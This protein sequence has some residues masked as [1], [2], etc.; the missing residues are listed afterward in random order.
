M[1]PNNFPKAF[2]E[3][4]LADEDVRLECVAYGY[5]VPSYNWTRLN[6]GGSQGRLPEGSYTTSHNRVLIIPKV[7]VEDMGEY[8][9]AASS[10]RDVISKIVTLSIQALP[11][12]KSPLTDKMMDRGETL[13]WACSAFG[14]PD[15]SYKWYK[16]GRELEPRDLHFEDGNRYKIRDNV[17]VIEGLTPGRDEGLYQCRAWN[18]LGSRFTSGQLTIQSLKPNFK[19]H[20]LDAEM[21]A[22]VGS[23]FTIR[24]Q[25]EAIPFPAFQWK[26]NG[27]FFGGG[28]RIQVLNNGYLHI[29]SV[30]VSDAGTY[31]CV[32][33]N[34]HGMDQTEGFLT[35][36]AQPRIVE[37]PRPKVVARVNDTIQ[38]ECLAYADNSLDVAYIWL[39]NGLR[40]N[41]TRMPQFSSGFDL[42]Y[43]KIS[44]LTFAEAGE[45]QCIVKTSVGMTAVKTELII[46]GPPNSP[47][48]VLAEELTATSAK[49]MWSDGSDNG[50]RTL[51]YTIEGRTNHNPEWAL[52]AQ[53]VTSFTADPQTGRRS[54]YVHN[55]LSPWSTYEF[56]V[57]AIN[58][59]GQGVP[60]DAS[61]QYNTE[62]APPLKA[63]F[64]VGGGG[65]K[66]GTLTITWSPL[67]P[68]DWNAP[69]IWYKIYYKAENEIDYRS[70]D[71]KAL[72]NIGLYTVSV[73]EENYFKRYRVAVKAINSYGEGPSSLEHEVYS[74]ESMPQ[75]QPSL[76]KAYPFN[77]T[78]LNVSW[79]PLD[80]TREKIRGRLIG[81][82]I[83]YWRNGHD[84][85]SDSQTLLSRGVDP[86]G[87]IVALQ[88]DNEY[89]VAV[90]AY[91][92][93]GSGPES[94][95][96]LARTYKASPQRPPTSVKVT[97]RDSTSV[98]VTW[99][100]VSTVGSN[101][102]PILGY[103]VRY[104]ESDQPIAKAREV[105]KYLDGGD[106]EAVISGL[107]PGKV[108][109]L[110]VLAYSWGGDGKMSS[111]AWEFRVGEGSP[112]KYSSFGSTI[113][114]T[115]MAALIMVCLIVNRNLT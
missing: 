104:W 41:F 46:H 28:G 72:G 30:Q 86:W 5:P 100:G 36:F 22:S 71:L 67:R 17:L 10:G 53:Y 102:E 20:P 83:K 111:P 1:F 70:K 21:Y 96:F 33:K 8:Q 107:V 34:E 105:Y 51:A 18:A 94:E 101:E 2:P 14:I 52:L 60:S 16:N 106:L 114:S 24:C 55:V 95:P 87:L 42:G 112:S 59:L 48:A 19:K 77:S 82:R 49:I 97:A 92:D 93:A 89:Y 54:I 64:S 84:P 43:L 68:E 12:F 66:A 32:A 57:S 108:Y 113:H 50:R 99:R 7:K 115:A 103:K 3:A 65:G 98:M 79:A 37:Q 80:I 11:T 63:P 31:T 75:V 25:P 109:K 91:N 69:D 62:K 27:Q 78:A 74:A 47:G 6:R 76:V 4:P 85:E 58:E 39:H 90:M 13:T 61:P 29:A 15:V 35:I 88:P 56:R 45:Y 44:N 110:R 73:G 9:C 81:H 23:N 38:L 40:V 26:R